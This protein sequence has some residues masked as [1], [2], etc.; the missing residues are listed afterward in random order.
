MSVGNTF[1]CVFRIQSIY[2]QCNFSLNFNVLALDF[3]LTFGA[4]QLKSSNASIAIQFHIHCSC[5]GINYRMTMGLLNIINDQR[6]SLLQ[7]I[8][9][10]PPLYCSSTLLVFWGE[11]IL[12][13]LPYQENLRRF[14]D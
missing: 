1:T 13:F 9:S 10:I 7:A 8:R 5:R 6:K 4:H 3:N 14:S 2:F 11:I 12:F